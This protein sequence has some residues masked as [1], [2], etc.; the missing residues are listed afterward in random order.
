[1]AAGSGGRTRSIHL[2]NMPLN[3][4]HSARVESRRVGAVYFQEGEVSQVRLTT[5]TRPG[6]EQDPHCA[7]VRWLLTN[8]GLPLHLVAS[9]Q[10][11]QS[12]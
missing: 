11:S 8:C 10:R 4:G 6:P 2:R 5:P 1:M 9:V 3:S 12:Q 7:P